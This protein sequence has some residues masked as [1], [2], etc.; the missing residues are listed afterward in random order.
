METR[1]DWL[2]WRSKGLGGSDAYIVMELTDWMTPLQLYEQKTAETVTE[3]EGNFATKLGDEAEPKIR[4]LFELVSGKSFEPCLVQ[5]HNFPFVRASLDG[6]TSDKRELL[7]IKLINA[8]DWDLAKNSDKV[9]EKYYCQIQHQ[10]IAS[11]CKV[12]WFVCYK[13]QEYKLSRKN[14]LDVENMAI[15]RVTP[16][17]SYQSRLLQRETDFWL[18]HVLKKKPPLPG[19]GDIVEMK[20]LEKRVEWFLE[21]KEKHEELTKHLSDAEAELK[22]AVEASGHLK[23]KSKGVTFAKI[24]RAGS[25]SVAK[26]PEV[27]RFAKEFAEKLTP[28]ERSKYTGN[29][30]IYWKITLPKKEN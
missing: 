20:E 8:K 18:N 2:E 17:P 27:V 19:G 24:S 29:G 9:P 1:Q 28:D 22:A 21:L 5:S 6:R 7:E 3:W 12:G 25:F 15:V 16:D 4:S 11:D 13:F 26:A 30:S 23:V 10:F 14:A